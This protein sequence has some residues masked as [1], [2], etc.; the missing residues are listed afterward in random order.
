MGKAD[1][2]FPFVSLCVEAFILEDGWN[3]DLVVLQVVSKLDLPQVNLCYNPSLIRLPRATKAT[4]AAKPTSQ[5]R[6]I[7]KDF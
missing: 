4:K 1:E 5:G 6:I 2:F 7:G 3:S